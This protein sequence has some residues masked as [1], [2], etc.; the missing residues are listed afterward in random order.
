M[1]TAVFKAF[2]NGF[3]TF[4]FDNGSEIMFDDALPKVLA[5]YDLKNDRSLLETEFY[6]TFTEKFD[7][8]DEDVVIYTIMSL[9]LL[10][11]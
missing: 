5:K 2:E 11:E 8:N 3:Y 7:R 4:W 6:I 9:K 1:E 10:S